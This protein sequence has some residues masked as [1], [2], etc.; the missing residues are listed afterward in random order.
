MPRGQLLSDVEKGQI[1][2]LRHE[3]IPIRRIAHTMQRS[4]GAVQGFLKRQNKPP[5]AQ[6]RPNAKK[7]SDQQVRALLREA[8]QGVLSASGI[9]SHLKLPVG[10]R[11]VQ[12]LLQGDP[13][14][15]YTKMTTAPKLSPKHE[16]ERLVWCRRHVGKGHFFW[17]ET[18]F[19]DEKKFNLDGPDGLSY[20]WHDLRREPRRFSKRQNGGGSVMVWAGLSFYGLTEIVFLEGR[21]DSQCYCATLEKA[22]LPFV[23]EIY[24]SQRI[25]RLQQ[26]N[27]PIHISAHTRDW[28]RRNSVNTLSW[29]AR[30]PDLNIIENLWG[31][32]VRRVYCNAR[33][34][35]NEQDL[36]EAIEEAWAT[37]DQESIS[38]LFRSLTRRMLAVIEVKGRATK[39]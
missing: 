24:G 6:R 23:A 3:L 13:D 25:W 8:K 14:L 27:A 38:R 39:Y 16:N 12:Q 31:L 17:H 36:K 9:V 28:M 18:I 30:S 35:G 11:R 22:L 33:Q 20:Y 19:S 1:L 15:R 21:Q 37:I 32:L 2:A 5:R 7:L 34:F 29:P 26:D 10:K 4:V